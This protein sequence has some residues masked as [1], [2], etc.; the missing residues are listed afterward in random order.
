MRVLFTSSLSY[1][2]QDAGG[3]KSSTHALCLG[4]KKG[5]HEVALLCGL[6]KDGWF[7]LWARLRRKISR[8][9]N[10]PVDHFFHYPAYRGWAVADG[11]PEVS[12][13]FRP[14]IAVADAGQT[15]LL[16]KALV[17]AGIPTVVYIHDV[18]FD[19]MGGAPF[20]DAMM[21]YISNSDFTA[22]V[23]SRQFGIDSIV[24]PPL[25]YPEHYQVH[26]DRSHVL[27]I[28]PH[29]IKGIDI[30]ME[31]ARRRP[32]I[33]FV[34]IEAWI[35]SVALLDKYRGM[36]SKLPNVVW[37]ERMPDMRKVYQHTR[38]VLAPSQWDEAW[39]RIAT[40]PH[41]SGIPV[42]ASARG[43]FPESVGPGGLL[44]D[45]SAPIDA[46]L[47]ALSRLWDN[48]EEY[49]RFATAASL[50][51]NRP[52]IQPDF[53]LSKFANALENHIKATNKLPR[54]N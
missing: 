42:I 3:S 37:K 49:V 41:V 32:D 43:G 39:G 1:P 50:Y 45:P 51:S 15:I 40:E 9:H 4:L 30:T 29:P 23:L 10:F 22:S 36:A 21:I 24:I 46:W 5:G 54:C 33:P 48:P 7:G 11:I 47:E 28:N 27:H 38:I 34:I 16:A 14:D 17:K 25:V 6:E 20:A 35:L 18:E 12:Q 53:L 44:V 26:S 8:Q 13:R 31:L 19:R 2:P 52:E